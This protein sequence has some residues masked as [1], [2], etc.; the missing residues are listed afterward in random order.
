MLQRNIKLPAKYV[1]GLSRAPC[2]PSGPRQPGPP[3]PSYATGDS[4]IQNIIL[5]RYA[6]DS[7]SFG[8]RPVMAGKTKRRRA[9][10]SKSKPHGPTAGLDHGSKGHFRGQEISSSS[11]EVAETYEVDVESSSERAEVAK[12]AEKSETVEER[13]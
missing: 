9:K 3:A 7:G 13:I 2:R 10:Q 8:M 5:F 12:P 4:L 6:S 11:S 1:D